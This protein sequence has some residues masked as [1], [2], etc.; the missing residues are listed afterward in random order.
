MQVKGGG[1]LAK[2]FENHDVM[3][4]FKSFIYP[5]PTDKGDGLQED[6]P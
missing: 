6:S 5:F 4:K 2:N 1:P 3:S